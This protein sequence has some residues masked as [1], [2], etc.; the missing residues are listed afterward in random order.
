M[1]EKTRKETRDAG[2]GRFL[3][4][5]AEKRR[6]ETTVRE[7]IPNRRPEPKKK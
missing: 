5:G 3:P 6:P 1:A 7:T 2:T 4:D